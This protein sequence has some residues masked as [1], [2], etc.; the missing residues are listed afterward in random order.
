[1]AARGALSSKDTNAMPTNERAP[2]GVAPGGRR[3]KSSGGSRPGSSSGASTARPRARGGPLRSKTTDSWKCRVPRV[4]VRSRVL[5]PMLTLPTISSRRPFARRLRVVP[6]I[7]RGHSP[8]VVDGGAGRRRRGRRCGRKRQGRQPATARQRDRRLQGQRR[9]PTG[10]V[11]GG[12]RRRARRFV[13]PRGI[14][15]TPGIVAVS[16]R[17]APVV[18]SGR[19]D[20]GGD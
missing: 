11:A 14:V 7:R 17:L 3:M 2:V 13:F 15:F 8:D 10:V 4:G 19:T 5:F 6:F 9:Q 16:P 1:M 12:E 20:R 18:V